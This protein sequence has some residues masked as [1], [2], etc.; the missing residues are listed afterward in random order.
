MTK[1]DREQREYK[2]LFTDERYARKAWKDF[3]GRSLEGVGKP[4]PA[5]IDPKTGEQTFNSLLD[6]QAYNNVKA[7]LEADGQDR[8]PMQAE[9]IVECNVLRS[10]FND[11]TFN[12]ILDRTAGKVKDEIS[13][14]PNEFE[15]LSDEELALLAKYREEQAM[16]NDTEEKKD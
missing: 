5:Q 14:T 1:T 8:E 13:I 15:S 10:R 9:I 7:R 3:I 2:S 4:L 12:T 6:Q 11:V 16:S